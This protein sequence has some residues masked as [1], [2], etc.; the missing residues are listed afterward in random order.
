M[1]CRHYLNEQLLKTQLWK[2]NEAG[3]SFSLDVDMIDVR[4]MEDVEI[5]VEAGLRILLSFTAHGS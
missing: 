4:E 2:F 1:A 3:I 5:D